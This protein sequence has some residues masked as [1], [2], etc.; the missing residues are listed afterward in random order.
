MVKLS[1]IFYNPINSYQSTIRITVCEIK[2]NETKN[3]KSNY[4]KS[5]FYRSFFPRFNKKKERL[6][7]VSSMKKLL[8]R[9]IFFTLTAIKARRL[10]SDSKV[11][12]LPRRSPC[13][14]RIG[15]A[16]HIQWKGAK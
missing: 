11:C 2:A 7:G 6:G 3:S 16:R 15:E 1:N 10:L 12:A 9:E 4:L 5:A 8:P 13:I 14:L